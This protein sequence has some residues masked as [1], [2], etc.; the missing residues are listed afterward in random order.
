[1][2]ASSKIMPWENSPMKASTS[3]THQPDNTRFVRV[4]HNRGGIIPSL[5]M[6]VAE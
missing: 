6:F 5:T 4:V 3:H 1:M 2:V